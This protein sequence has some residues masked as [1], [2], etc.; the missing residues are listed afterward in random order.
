LRPAVA[1]D[2]LPAGVA[3]TTMG[4]AAFVLGLPFPA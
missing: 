1:S 4:V 2:L 3:V